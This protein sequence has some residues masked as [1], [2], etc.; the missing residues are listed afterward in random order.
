MFPVL[1]GI[2]GAELAARI[3]IFFFFLFTATAMAY[4]NSW[5]RDQIGAAAEM[6][7]TAT[8]ML[9]PEPTEQGQESNL[10]PHRDFGSL[11]C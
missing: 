5:A 7:I 9:D 1:V 11:T 8:A 6:Y 3:H 4:G 2:T 10:H